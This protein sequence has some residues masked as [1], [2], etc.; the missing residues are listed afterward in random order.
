MPLPTVVLENNFGEQTTNYVKGGTNP[1]LTTPIANQ[2]I[3][4]NISGSTAIPIGLT[5][6]QVGT[7]VPATSVTAKV[8]TGLVAGAAT[9]ILETDTILAALAKLQAQIDAL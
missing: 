7:F 3:V 1:D 6:A 5:A 2:R 4:G 8:L 9:T